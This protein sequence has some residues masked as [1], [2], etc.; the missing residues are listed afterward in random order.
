MGANLS[1]YTERGERTRLITL[2]PS[3]LGLIV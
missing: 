2:S 1:P 3:L